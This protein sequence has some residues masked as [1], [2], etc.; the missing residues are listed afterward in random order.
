[1]F[2][3]DPGKA[4]SNLLK[5]GVSFEEAISVFDDPHPMVVEDSAHSQIE[6]RWILIG[7][8]SNRRALSIAYTVR[9]TN[10]IETIRIIAARPA[11]KRERET[12]ARQRNR[13]FRFS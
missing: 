6:Q 8:S 2:T 4:A 11:S 7:Y 13:F 12:A 9:R 10:E 5:H 3:W 1:M